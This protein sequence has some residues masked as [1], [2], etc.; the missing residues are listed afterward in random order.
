LI[1]GSL[2]YYDSRN[3]TTQARR[4]KVCPKCGKQYPEDAN[5][6]P[7][8]AGRLVVDDQLNAQPTEEAAE[9]AAPP[10]GGDR[11][12][13]GR[14]KLGDRIGGGLTGDVHRAVDQDTG[15]SCAVKL[16]DTSVFPSSL[17]LQRTER[18]LRQ[19]V[20]LDSAGIA[21]VHAHGR[22]G[23]TLWIATELLPDSRSLHE[24][25]FDDGPLDLAR[26]SRIVLAVGQALADAAK[27]G[28]IHRDLAPKNVLLVSADRIKI[29]NFGVAV[30]TTEKVAGVA[31]FVAPEMIE[32]K[33]VDQRANIYSLGALFYYLLTGR[34]PFMGEP[35]EVF[36]QHLKGTPEPPSEHAE[37]PEVVDAVVLKALERSS[38]KRFMTLRQFLS[39]VEHLAQG[40]LDEVSP[41]ITLP[42]A[43]AGKGK[44]KK[45]QLSST[46]LG[47]GA[48]TGQAAAVSG[49]STTQA[50]GEPDAGATQKLGSAALGSAPASPAP[51]GAAPARTQDVVAPQASPAAAAASIAQAVSPPAAVTPG[52]FTTPEPAPQESAP[53][54]SAPR[55]SLAQE[56]A[57]QP[58]LAPQQSAAAPQQPAAA[59]QQPVARA[60]APG[61]QVEQEASPAAAGSGQAAGERVIEAGKKR[62]DKKGQ[63]RETLWFKKGEL[64]PATA[65]VGEK[66]SGEAG[67]AAV[68]DRYEDDGSLTRGDREK[69]SLKTGGTHSMPAFGRTPA[70]EDVS[71]KELIDEMKTGRR[72]II[73]LIA[74]GIL[75]LIVVIVFAVASGSEGE[76]KDKGPIESG[77]RPGAAE[78]A[79]PQPTAPQ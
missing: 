22:D 67:D 40:N 18:E 45:R 73:A 56:P 15:A 75:L 44:E 27:V 41:A 28:V 35:E 74:I 47:Y 66:E 70:R 43:S 21:K 5:F 12:A 3:Y 26:A 63:F 19:L 59:P 16:V 61:R 24:L 2:F 13:G 60:A 51:A 55:Q 46:M 33:P 10:A 68:D 9:P 32:G 79:A 76:D 11:V 53:Q 7:L 25:V 78:P 1:R 48:K 30:P 64:D 38:S 23:G 8:D 31:E 17:L 14:F 69:F 52:P 77:A 62:K 49:E 54:E 37:L 6:C 50:A 29:I 39:A 42:M 36:E 20:R 58:S 34:A 4:M 65:A 72:K 57:P 71:S